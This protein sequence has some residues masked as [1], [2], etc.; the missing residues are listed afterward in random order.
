MNNYEVP[1]VV[2]MGKAQDVIL[3]LGKLL[4]IVFDSPSQPDRDPDMNDD[5]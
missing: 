2:E 4:Q 5:E 3:G 1:E